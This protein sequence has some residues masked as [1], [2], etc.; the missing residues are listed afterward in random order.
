MN[1]FIEKFV[2]IKKRWAIT[3]LLLPMFLLSVGAA[4]QNVNIKGKIIDPDGN[5]LPGTAITVKGSTI[6]ATTNDEGDY[7]LPNVPAGSTLVIQLVGFVSQEI[8]VEEGK[9]IYNAILLEES[10]SLDEVTVVA[11]ST[12]KKESVLASITTV[13]PSELKVPSSN[14]TTAFAG[15]I[16]GLISYQ[17]SGEPGQDNAQF[18]IRGVTSFGTG[19]VDPLILIDGVEMTTDDLARLTTDDISSFS[20]MKDANAT[21]LYGARGA[22]GVI[23][24]TT[25]EGKEG[26]AKISLRVEGSLSMPTRMVDVADPLTYMKMN[27]EAY[28]MYDFQSIGNLG[29]SYYSED[30][31]WARERGLDPER[32]PMV[33]WTNMLFKDNTMNHRYNLNVSGGGTVVRYYVAAS[34][35]RDNGIINMDERNNFNNNIAI[36]KYALRS[37]VNI[38]LSKTTELI[39]RLNAA[40]DDYSGPLDGGADLFNK[41]RNANPVRFLPYYAP[42]DAHL[43][44]NYI[45]FGN[46]TVGRTNDKWHLNPYAEMVKGYRTEDRSSMSSQFELKQNFKFITEGLSARAMIN[47]NR[48][49]K[50]AAKRAYQPHY[51]NLAPAIPGEDIRVLEYLNEKD[52]P[53]SY[54]QQIKGTPEIDQTM[55]F[56]TAVQYNRDFAKK[57]AVSGLLVYTML[58]Y[59][60]TAAS[61]EDNV[62][63]ALPHRNLGLAGRLTYGYDSRYFV[64]FNFG[65]NGSERFDKT[66][67]FGFFPS[68]GVGYILTNEKFMEPFKNVLSKLKLKATYGLVGN[69]EIGKD[70]DRFYYLSD[71]NMNVDGKKYQSYR[72]GRKNIT[73][74]SP[75]PAVEFKRYADPYITWE[76]SRK[77]NFGIELNFWNS[78][79]IQMDYAMEYRSNILQTRV[80][81]TTMGLGSYEDNNNYVSIIPKANIGE[82][83]GRS[84]EVMVDYSKSF[85]KDFWTVFRG[86]FTY[87]T[88]KYEVF[89]EM[90]YLEGPRRAHV[91]QSVTQRYGYIAERLFFDSEEVA[92]SPSQIALGN[93]RGGDIKYKDING[94]YKID[95]NDKVPIGYPFV[96][97][98]NYGFGLSFGYKNVDFSCFFQGSARSS[99][100]IDAK[101]TAPFINDMG[102]DVTANRALLQAYADNHWS[103]TNMNVYALWPRLAPIFMS[104]NGFGSGRDHDGSGEDE[105]LSTWFMRNGAF[106]RVKSVELGYTLP[107][108]WTESIK[109][110]NIRFYASGTNLFVFSKFK[111]W[112]PEMGSNGL[113]YPV[114]RVINLGVKLDF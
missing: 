101:A 75:G 24:V 87:A 107:K 106:L 96:P 82:A 67:R 48:Y 27:N 17:M 92:N 7:V 69:D 40:F 15:R 83:S 89:E 38:N 61:T 59:E 33:D 62:Q 52:D 71:I 37:N 49:S 35:N 60:N 111:M 20:I 18:F 41:A 79:E 34:F 74:E 65:Y 47:I 85:N 56:E 13:K 80:I 113:A 86:T 58:D 77:T 45:L 6:G 36:N 5:A 70:T 30:E 68:A 63:L 28:R 95:R 64:E 39:A 8:K 103:Q 110:Q 4:A 32:Y 81:P 50:L 43:L 25:K 98:I 1:K 99:F 57:H 109:L 66:E 114:Q 112:D 3:Y 88:S 91:G 51:F 21:A 104:N 53:K 22:N 78:L 23:M 46:S 100:W 11:F 97:E 29:S 14:L 105:Q 16:A 42:D 10:T 44:S 26:K 94:D 19:K 54:L 108:Q 93:A 76:I 102:N 73:A 90:N 55:Y 2:K 84:F 31:I 72:F 9:T 12:Q